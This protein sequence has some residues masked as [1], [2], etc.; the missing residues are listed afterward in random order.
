MSAPYPHLSLNPSLRAAAGGWART[1]AGREGYSGGAEDRGAHGAVNAVSGVSSVRRFGRPVSC[2]ALRASDVSSGTGFAGRRLAA[3]VADLSI[4]PSW[5]AVAGGW[6]R[7]AAGPKGCS[8][9]AEGGHN[10]GAANAICGASSAGRFK[11]RGDGAQQENFAVFSAESEG[12]GY[13]RTRGRG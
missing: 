6:V 10:L 13:C 2:V 1:A 12:E 3:L 9:G 7:V 11:W 8:G 4:N 5:L